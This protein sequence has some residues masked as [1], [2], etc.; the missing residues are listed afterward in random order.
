MNDAS[1]KY[2]LPNRRD[3]LLSLEA[4]CFLSSWT[5]TIR[6]PCGREQQPPLPELAQVKL[7]DLEKRT[8][9]NLVRRLTCQD[10]GQ[11]PISVVVE[12]LPSNVREE[13]VAAG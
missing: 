7:K 2:E 8:L 6:C 13:L 1:L 11:K 9:G 3:M 4:H 10:C 12:H 5:I